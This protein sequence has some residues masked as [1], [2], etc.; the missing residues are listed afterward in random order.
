MYAMIL[1][2]CHVSYTITFTKATNKFVLGTSRDY[3]YS[4]LYTRIISIHV[5]Y[6]VFLIIY[7][8]IFI[9]RSGMLG[10]V[11]RYDAPTSNNKQLN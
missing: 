5:K 7:A 9:Y 8:R 2:N 4:I 3:L 1:E 6:R 10:W 11:N